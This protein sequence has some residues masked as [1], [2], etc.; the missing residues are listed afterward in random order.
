[1]FLRA[2]VSIEV[3]FPEGERKMGEEK[4]F[5]ILRCS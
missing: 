3:S 1:M 4:F 5:K 2:L